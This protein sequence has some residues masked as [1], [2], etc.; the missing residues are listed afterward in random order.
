MFSSVG[1][2]FPLA[3]SG[4]SSG[5]NAANHFSHPDTRTLTGQAL[6][7]SQTIAH[8]GQMRVLQDTGQASPVAASTGP[9]L[10]E[11]VFQGAEHILLTAHVDLVALRNES[12]GDYLLGKIPTTIKSIRVC[13]NPFSS[14]TLPHQRC[15]PKIP[16]SGQLHDHTASTKENLAT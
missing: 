14:C 7:V 12:T 16:H 5:M 2:S 15:I 13:P 6:Q 11:A 9:E 10:M 1:K 4:R 3:F 8:S